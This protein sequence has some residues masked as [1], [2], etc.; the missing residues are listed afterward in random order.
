[1]FEDH[2]KSLI[3]YRER[4]E[5]RLQVDKSSS[6]MPKTVHFESFWKA[7]PC[8]QTVLP[9]RP[10]LIRQKLL[11]NT[12]YLRNF[13]TLYNC[14]IFHFSLF[15]QWHESH[16]AKWKAVLNWWSRQIMFHFKIAPLTKKVGE[17]W[18]TKRLLPNLKDSIPQS[19]KGNR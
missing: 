7:E 15:S 16:L 12:T 18:S 3:Q 11:K 8:C 14:S 4:S 2:R 17:K 9:D 13:Q 10:F 6:K 1:M 19:V 5:L